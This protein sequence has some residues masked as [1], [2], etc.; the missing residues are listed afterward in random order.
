M[1]ISS[2]VKNWQPVK[3]KT[4]MMIYYNMHIATVSN[5]KFPTS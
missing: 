3:I 4:D 2:I 1:L 5:K